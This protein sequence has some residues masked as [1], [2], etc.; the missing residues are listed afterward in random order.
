MKNKDCVAAEGKTKPTK[1]ED[2]SA[3]LDTAFPLLK[4]LLEKS[5]TCKAEYHKVVSAF[6]RG[7]ACSVC[8]GTDKIE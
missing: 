8:A 2:I 3:L 1:V 4:D 5:K 6:A 7:A